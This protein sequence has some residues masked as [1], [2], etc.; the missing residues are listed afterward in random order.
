MNKVWSKTGAA[1]LGAIAL[2]LAVAVGAVGFVATYKK[3]ATVTKIIDGD[4]IDV[5]LG[6]KTERIR[7]LNVDTPEMDQPECLSLEAKEFLESKIPV[8]TE[9]RLGYDAERTD[10][11]GR[12]LAAVFLGD[13]LINSS[14]ARAGLGKAVVFGKNSKYFADVQQAEA[15]AKGKHVGIHG[16]V[17][18][19]CAL[20]KEL[21][22]AIQGLTEAQSEPG[23]G[24]K[25]IDSTVAEIVAAVAVA[26]QVSSKIAKLGAAERKAVS[27]MLR[28]TGHVISDLASARR[29]ATNTQ[30]DLNK[31]RSALVKA[32]KEAERKKK[33]AERKKA[34]AAKREAAR[35]KQAAEQ[36]RLAE[37][38]RQQRAVS[39]PQQYR[40][41]PSPPPAPAPAQQYKPKP[42]PPPQQY[43]PQPA[44]PPANPYPGYNGPRCYAPGGK[45]W[46]PCPKKG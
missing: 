42:P 39:P 26:D 25:A 2:V 4:T 6:G 32:Q 14:L 45:T 13:E 7:L 22:S 44:P 16:K 38:Q 20:A 11:Y 36:K 33:E 46:K 10:R 9:I 24:I 21:S 12:T 18:D 1:A 41:K 27:H 19:Y 30:S 31:K 43:R 34:E 15:E 8:G 29:K 40:P 35:K 23:T 37:L 5:S 28:G 3:P 17:P